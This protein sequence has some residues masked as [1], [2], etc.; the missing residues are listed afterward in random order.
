MW[1][2]AHINA[3]D[4]FVAAWLPGSEGAAI[5]DV[6]VANTDGSPRYDFSGRLS[7]DWP[8]ADLNATDPDLPV[9]DIL[10]EYGY[11]LSYAQTEIVGTLNEDAVRQPVTMDRLVLGERRGILGKRLLVTLWIGKSKS[12]GP[13]EPPVVAT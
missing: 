3:S 9:T 7:F 2:N 4:A 11:G 1:V 12:T 13:V 6:L 8:N 10:F 5:A